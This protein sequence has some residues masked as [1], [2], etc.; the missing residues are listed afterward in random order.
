[1]KGRLRVMSTV[2][3]VADI[4]AAKNALQNYITTCNEITGNLE[5]EI[6]NLTAQGSNFNGDSSMGYLEYF[7][8]IKR[9]LNTNLVNP[10]TSLTNTLDRILDSVNESLLNQVDPGL[11]N[12]NRNA[13]AE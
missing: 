3:K 1:M 13:V 7:E 2:L 6:N 4:Q 11:G 10:D 9:A 5:S 8:H 12:A